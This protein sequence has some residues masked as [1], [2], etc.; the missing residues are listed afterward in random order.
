MAEATPL[1]EL[2]ARAGAVFT[3]EA[4]WK[5]PAHFGDAGREYNEARSGCAVFDHSARGKVEVGGADSARFLH[6]LTTN[7]VLSLPSGAGCEAF[8]TTAKARVVAYGRLYR[9]DTADGGPAFWLDLAPGTAPIVIQHLDHYLVSERVEFGDHT[10]ALAQLHVAGPRAGAVLGGVLAGPLPAAHLGVL[11]AQGRFG[12]SQ[13]RR[14]DWPGMPAYDVLCG[15]DR[16]G[17]LWHALVAAGGRPAGRDAFE[18]LRVESGVPAQ[19]PDIDENTFAPEAGRTGQAIC[20]TKGCY[21]GQEPIVMARDRGHINRTL[22]RIALPEGPVPSGS[23]LF[24]EGRE[25]G[26]VTSSAAAGGTGVGLAS[27][28]RG[29]QDSGTEL[30]VEVGGIRRPALI[31]ATQ[32]ASGS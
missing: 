29:H 16:A 3:D 31:L 8:L 27:V 32:E 20:Y 17:E 9:L 10:A 4:G 30:E 2:A 26:R 15:S 24:A 19:G 12:E 14:W 28:R 18:R 25:V 13:V 5:V 11:R 1:F 6:N 22:V 23:P 21:L 7:D